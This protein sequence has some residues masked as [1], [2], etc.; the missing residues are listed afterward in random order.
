MAQLASA[1]SRLSFLFVVGLAAVLASPAGA[2]TIYAKFYKGG[3]GYTG[4]FNGA[5]TVYDATKG[6]A[7]DCPTTP[8]GCGSGDRLADPMIFGGK[9]ITATAGPDSRYVNNMPWN[10]LSPNFG[11]LGVGTGSPSDSDQIALTDVLTLTFSTQIELTGVATLFDAGHTPFGTGF[12]DGNAVKTANQ[13][14]PLTFLLSVDTIDGG[15]FHAYTFNAANMMQL[16][17]T[18]TV[19]KFMQ[20][21]GQNPEYY[22]SAVSYITCGPNGA[23]CAPPPGQT[24]IPGALPLFSGGVGLIGLLGWRR[25]RKALATA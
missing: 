17:L 2:A 5:G 20:N 22:V 13:A 10:D 9:G 4:P 12:P 23:G 6:L 7:T 24:P 8:S 3:S 16:T 15:A 21:A 25:K 11:G 1:V 19:F 18:G 14:N